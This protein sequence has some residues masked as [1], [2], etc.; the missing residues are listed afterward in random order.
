MQNTFL[1]DGQ[2]TGDVIDVEP[3]TV[4]QSKLSTSADFS[5]EIRSGLS[6]DVKSFCRGIDIPFQSLQG[7]WSKAE[8]LLFYYRK[9]KKVPNFT[10]LAVSGMPAGRGRKG[11]VPPRKKERQ[12]PVESRV[13][14][15]V[16]VSTTSGVVSISQSY[17]S[18]V[19]TSQAY[20][21]ACESPVYASQTPGFSPRAPGFQGQPPCFS[22]RGFSPSTSGYPLVDHGFFS[23]SFTPPLQVVLYLR[24]RIYLPRVSS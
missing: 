23:V 8:E 3:A 4:V 14:M 15:A 7:I 17:D 6:I 10:D 13:P 24:K 19:S 1:E 12:T 16:T 21:S 22:P 11:S 20:Y 18:P 2:A 9:L 5:S